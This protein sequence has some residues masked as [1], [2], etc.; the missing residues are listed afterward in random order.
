MLC[1]TNILGG[2]GGVPVFV[3]FNCHSE[4]FL[5]FVRSLTCYLTVV[6]VISFS[7]FASF[8]FV[9]CKSQ[10]YF[11]YCIVIQIWVAFNFILFCTFFLN[12]YI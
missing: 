1:N 6:A 9:S 10:P 5:C 3:G 8:S 12:I 2:G 7:N 4:L 11:Q